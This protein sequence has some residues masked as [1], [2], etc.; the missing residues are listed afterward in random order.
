MCVCM[1]VC[2][3]FFL[4][5]PTVFVGGNFKT[6]TQKKIFFFAVSYRLSRTKCLQKLRNCARNKS[7]A[8]GKKK[9][10]KVLREH[11]TKQ[12]KKNEVMTCLYAMPKTDP[13][14]AIQY[15]HTHHRELLE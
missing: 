15:T 2:M 3:F 7:V 9:T 12:P 14:V 1:Y 6:H 10:K 8:R 5:N 4:R 11:V 13:T